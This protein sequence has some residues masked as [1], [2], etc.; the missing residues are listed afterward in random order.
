MNLP[1]LLGFNHE[2]LAYRYNG[3]DFRLTDVIWERGEAGGGVRILK[4]TVLDE[5]RSH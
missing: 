2:K 5:S 3:R 4:V 1:H